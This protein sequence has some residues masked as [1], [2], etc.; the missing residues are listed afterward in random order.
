MTPEDAARSPEYAKPEHSEPDDPDFDSGRGL[1]VGMWISV[2]FL[3]AVFAFLFLC[4]RGDG[5]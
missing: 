2:V 3:G 1:A 4:V 5:L